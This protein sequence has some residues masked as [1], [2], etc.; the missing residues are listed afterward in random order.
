MAE[1]RHTSGICHV[2]RS[3]DLRE[4]TSLSGIAGIAA[5]HV[6]QVGAMRFQSL[7]HVRLA[8]EFL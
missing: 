3:C 8:Q 6:S 2:V 7:A 5:G 4:H 1:A